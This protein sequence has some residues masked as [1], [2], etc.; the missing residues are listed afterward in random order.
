ALRLESRNLNDVSSQYPELGRLNRAL[1]SHEAVLDGEIVAFDG[2]GRPSFEALQ[3]RMHV[4]ARAQVKR[5]AQSVPVTYLIFDVLWLDGHSLLELPYA[6]RR[7]R[8]AALALDGEAWQTPHYLPGPG[9]EVL[10]ASAEQGLEGIVA[11]RLDSTY[12]PGARTASWLKVKNIGRQELVIGGWVPGEGRRRQRIG[13]LLVGVYD[14]HG[15]RRYAGRVGT[16]FS[17]QELD[18]LA[19]LLAPLE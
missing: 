8:L 4:S 7:E 3:Q 9:A 13:A 10:R 12:Q 5:L 14:E 1:S 18:R 2:Q 19:G 16:G 6:E 15:A 11:K 17:N